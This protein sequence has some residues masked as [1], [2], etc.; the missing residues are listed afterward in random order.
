MF[1]CWVSRW[2]SAPVTDAGLRIAE[3]GRDTYECELANCH[4]GVYQ[5]LEKL[6]PMMYVLARAS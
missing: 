6:C 3:H 2:Y 5:M 1:W 4:W